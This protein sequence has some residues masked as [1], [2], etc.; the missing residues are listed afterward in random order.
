MSDL[1]D[2]QMENK[3]Y[4]EQAELFQKK[5]KE[6]YFNYLAQSQIIS[7]QRK[8]IDMTGIK[9]K[10]YGKLLNIF[11]LIFVGV[12]LFLFWLIFK[13]IFKH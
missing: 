12:D 1:L 6:L 10:D 11:L 13:L 2:L 3:L 8:V 7:Q 9:P 4:K 5:Y